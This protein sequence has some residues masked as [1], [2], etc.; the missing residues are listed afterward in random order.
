MIEA[1]VVIMAEDRRARSFVDE[2]IKRRQVAEQIREAA[3]TW[4]AEGKDVSSAGSN[5][6][7]G[8]DRA[9]AWFGQRVL[10]GRAEATMLAKVFYQLATL[11]E[12]GGGGGGGGGS[13][14]SRS[15][16]RSKSRNRSRGKGGS[17]GGSKSRSRGRSKSDSESSSSRGSSIGVSIGL[18]ENRLRRW[19]D[20]CA[21]CMAEDQPSDHALIQC[22]VETSV[23]A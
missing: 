21:V 16:S 1:V 4:L 20:R 17:R 23:A 13:S 15:G 14:R 3:V 9:L 8:L 19:K 12:R 18:I 2:W 10:W 5:S 22:Q 7:V 11:A 6:E